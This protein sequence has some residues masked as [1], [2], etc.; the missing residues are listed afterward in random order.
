MNR[1]DIWTDGSC[2][3]KKEGKGSREGGFGVVIRMYDEYGKIIGKKNYSEGKF[4]NTS[5]AR[6]ELLA[7]IRSLELVKPTKNKIHIFTDNQYVRNSIEKGW[8][9]NWISTGQQKAN[10]DLWNQFIKLYQLHGRCGGVTVHWIKGHQKDNLY[11]FNELADHLAC[12]GRLSKTIV[13]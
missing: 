12:Q 9:D 10:M 13:K 1:I 4:I 11:P 6:M 8:L 7:V 2:I 5:S 3:N